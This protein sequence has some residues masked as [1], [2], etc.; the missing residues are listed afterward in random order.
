MSNTVIHKRSSVA[1]KKPA[2]ADIAVGEIAIN[3]ADAKAFSKDTGGNII[4]LGGSAGILNIDGGA[5][6]SVYTGVGS[7][8]VDGGL[9]A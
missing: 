3:L 8:P 2:S 6:D 9:S 5:S 1:G 7:S 4:E